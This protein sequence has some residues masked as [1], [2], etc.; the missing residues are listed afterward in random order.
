[1]E[2]ILFSLQTTSNMF[3]TPFFHQ[4]EMSSIMLR[5]PLKTCLKQKGNRE[6]DLIS[7]RFQVMEV[8]KSKPR[9]KID[10]F[11]LSP[12]GTE[13]YYSLYED[14]GDTVYSFSLED[15]IEKGVV[16]ADSA[17]VDMSYYS[18]RISPN[19]RM[20]A[21]TAVSE[22]SQDSSLFEY[23]L[24]LLNIDSKEMKQL[25]DLH[26]SVQSPAFFHNEQKIAFL[27]QHNRPSQPEQY[28]LMT[29]D[30]ESGEPA[31][32]SIEALPQS[33][34]GQWFLRALDLS[35]NSGTIGLLYTLL[36]V[37]L[38]LF[39]RQRLQK[40]FLPAF[41]SLGLTIIVFISSF[42]AAAMMDPWAGIALVML[43]AGMMV[44]TILVFLFALITKLVKKRMMQ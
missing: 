18:P 29:V 6:K 9:L 17:P 27:Y 38:T 10:I 44:Y 23:E 5:L 37:A 40:I 42:A 43:S 19:G 4:V 1:M 2:G 11:S 20:L 39:T 22:E 33:E 14:T 30:L 7:F 26:A 36:L 41:V 25:T 35:V 24:F 3:L 32:I 21:F 16:T 31:E 12:D 15:G 34:G 28:R 8:K 13:L